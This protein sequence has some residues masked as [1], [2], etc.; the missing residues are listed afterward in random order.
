ML[1][2]GG[3][4]VYLDSSEGVLP[5]FTGLGFKMPEHENPADWFMD[6]ISGKA[7]GEPN[8]KQEQERFNQTL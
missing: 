8:D 1:G 2:L 5:Y 6:V 3:R 7:R 4:T